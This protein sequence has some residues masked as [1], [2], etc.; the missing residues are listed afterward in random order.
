MSGRRL[1]TAA[2][3]PALLPAHAEEGKVFEKLTQQQ[4]RALR[5]ASGRGALAEYVAFV[6]DI[7][8]G[9]G[10]QVNVAAAKASRWA[11]KNRLKRAAGEAG[12]EIRFLRS[13]EETVVFE[14]VG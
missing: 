3:G 2:F 7:P 9:Q 14:V 8:M 12:K 6:A 5:G 11:V 13:G 1:F 10:G 4:V